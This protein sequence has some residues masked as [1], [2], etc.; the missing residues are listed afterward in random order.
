MTVLPLI[1]AAVVGA[2]YFDADPRYYT[3]GAKPVAVAEGVTCE[4][5]YSAYAL[6]FVF[7]GA[8]EPSGKF[9]FQA[10][11]G[12]RNCAFPVAP[13]VY[14][15]ENRYDGNVRDL[16]A[17]TAHSRLTPHIAAT[18]ET[19]PGRKGGWET[20][21]SLPFRGRLSWWPFPKGSQRPPNWFAAVR[22]VDA[23]GKATDWG[24]PADPLQI[25]WGR[26][27]TFKVGL[28]GLLTDPVLV[29]AYIDMRAKYLDV[30]DYSQKEK[31]IGYLDPGVETFAWR[32]ADSEKLF[33]DAYAAAIANE[34]DEALKLLVYGKDEYGRKVTP[35][36]A[37]KLAEPAKERLFSMIDDFNYA[38]DIFTASRLKYLRDRFMGRKV[39][40]V[41]VKAKKKQSAA[42]QLTAPDA[43][44][45]EGSISLDDDEL[46]F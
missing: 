28:E 27:P 36:K 43:S 18:I 45:E 24:T 8:G 12:A 2:K 4:L 44:A 7:R 21:V 15:I 19:K 42:S 30:Y 35:P 17:P 38:S 41:E 3:S 16:L 10:R 22:Y 23:A 14:E 34:Y 9:V 29:D 5:C 13:F 32:Q 11:P 33:N 37:T 40:A 6:R 26:P 25:G 46:Q 39:S 31:W 20:Y 1:L